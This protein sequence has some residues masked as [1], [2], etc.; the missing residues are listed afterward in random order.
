MLEVTNISYRYSKENWL[1]EQISMEVQPG[2]V[3]GV[4]GKSGMGKTTM[5]KIIAG[6]IEP[7]EGTVA[8]DGIKP[9]LN[10]ISPVQFIWQHPEKVINPRW[11]MK[12][13]L[14]ESGNIDPSLLSRF[15]IHDE[16]LFRF[17]YQLSGGELQRF[18]IVRVLSVAPPYIIADEI[19]TMLDAISQAQIWQMILHFARQRNIGIV[20]ISHDQQLLLRIC[21]RIINFD[22]LISNP[23]IND[24][25]I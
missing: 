8:I 19:T 21:N 16:W 23:R 24:Q 25:K 20:A 2:E 14:A 15:G 7:T 5:A 18:C 17:P 22:R 3:V 1:F 6:Y 13:V 4:Y 10:K 11:R 9:S 12:K